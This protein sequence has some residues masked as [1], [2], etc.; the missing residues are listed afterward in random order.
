MA[1]FKQSDNYKSLPVVEVD[2]QML[3]TGYWP[4]KTV[5]SCRLP[6]NITACCKLFSDFYLQKYQGRKLVWVTQHGSAEIK[7]TYKQGRRDFTVST[8]QMCILSIFNEGNCFSLHKIVEAL[9]A[10]DELEVKRHLLSLCTP[11]T[12]ILVKKSKV[13]GILPDDDFTF[14]EEFTSKLKRIKVPLISMR[15]ITGENTPLKTSNRDELPPTVEE[16]RRHLIEASIVRIMKTRKT[17]VH[18][19]L[20]AE[21][22]RQLQTRFMPQAAAIKK[23]IESLIERDYLDRD[24]DDARLYTY[25]A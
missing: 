22:T 5:P 3:T 4:I 1:E 14:N 21:V 2:V 10:P 25:M 23:R 6:S 11:K 8:Y 18:N 15:E 20:I 24:K 19:E 12:R 9:G 7:A 17:L 13:K 16:D